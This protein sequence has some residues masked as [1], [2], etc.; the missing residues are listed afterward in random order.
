MASPGG[1]SGGHLVNMLRTLEDLRIAGDAEPVQREIAKMLCM[2]ARTAPENSR[3][4]GNR[5]FLVGLA[6]PL[7]TEK[8]SCEARLHLAAS[9]VSP[10]KEIEAKLRARPMGPRFPGQKILPA[11]S[12]KWGA[13]STIILGSPDAGW[14]RYGANW[15]RRSFR[16]RRQVM[17]ATR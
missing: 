5:S 1:S 7:P 16:L 2:V 13:V 9:P 11:S 4:G 6:H 8:S 15:D 3:N 12:V 14:A 10:R 17:A